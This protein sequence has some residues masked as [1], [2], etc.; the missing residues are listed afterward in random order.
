MATLGELS[1]LLSPPLT[2]A[3]SAP[4]HARTQADRRPVPNA[5]ILAML[6][7]GVALACL[8]LVLIVTNA[9]EM[10]QELQNFL[11]MRITLRN[12]LV[13]GLLI[14][15]WRFVFQ[16]WG[17]YSVRGVRSAPASGFASSGP[18]APVRSSP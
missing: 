9:Q 3:A 14:A 12:V 1:S 11:A 7:A 16:V 10:P 15:E 13:L 5:G 8:L 18:A 6:D 17:L 4:R 2:R